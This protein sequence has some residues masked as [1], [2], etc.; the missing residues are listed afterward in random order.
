[1]ASLRDLVVCRDPDGAALL[2]LLNEHAEAHEGDVTAIEEALA[3]WWQEH[4]RAI[5]RK[6]EAVAWVLRELEARAEAQRAAA[7]AIAEAARRAEAACER[8]RGYV[9]LSMREAGLQRL[10]GTTV[11]LRRQKN[12]GVVPV[13]IECP[14]ESL[15]PDLQAVKIEANKAAIREALE[16]GATVPGCSL[17]E[18]SER[19]V[20]R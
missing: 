10:A 6:A 3:P 5:E 19:L 13:I 14:P 17:G 18:R 12:G 4:D 8:I 2:E 11:E 9:L 7:K 15:P 16:R 1:M 20:L